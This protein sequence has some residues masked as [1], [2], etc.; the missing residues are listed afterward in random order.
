MMK[1]WKGRKGNKPINRK[2]KRGPKGLQ[3]LGFWWHT[4]LCKQ[5][6][7]ETQ[8]GI[9]WWRRKVCIISAALLFIA[10]FFLLSCP[11]L[12]AQFVL[13]LWVLKK[14]TLQ[15]EQWIWFSNELGRSY[16]GL[17]MVLVSKRNVALCWW[18]LYLFAT[19]LALFPVSC[20][21]YNLT[22]PSNQIQQNLLPLASSL[23]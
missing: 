1:N 12:T 5:I 15:K 14:A 20:G 21:L 10:D 19:F 23:Q 4:H 11:K 13:S 8:P 18:A 17:V 22:Q 16:G 9:D 3:D 6:A 2:G 7:E